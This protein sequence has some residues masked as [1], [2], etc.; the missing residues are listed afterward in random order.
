MLSAG[1]SG[2]LFVFLGLKML[3]NSKKITS[4][5]ILLLYIE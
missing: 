2:Q 5:T 4:Y 3:D 1:H